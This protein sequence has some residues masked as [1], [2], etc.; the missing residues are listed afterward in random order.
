VANDRN[1]LSQAGWDCLSVS[2]PVRWY[3]LV[4]ASFVSKVPRGDYATDGS[5]LAVRLGVK[6][7]IKC[8]ASCDPARGGELFF[9][10]WVFSLRSAGQSAAAC[11]PARR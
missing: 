11:L 5:L 8:D 6:R 3:D 4:L 1:P 10:A 9:L 7:K 2:H